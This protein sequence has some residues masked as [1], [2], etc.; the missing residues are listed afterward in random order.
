[1]LKDRQ[2]PVGT[3]IRVPI[4]WMKQSLAGVKPLR[5]PGARYEIH[6]PAAVTVVRGTQF[7]IAAE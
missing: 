4:D 5:A 6:T 1:V 3:E 7:R 2:M